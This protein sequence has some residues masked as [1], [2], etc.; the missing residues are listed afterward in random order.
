MGWLHGEH[1]AKI[2]K[3]YSAAVCRFFESSSFS[4]ITTIGQSCVARIIRVSVAQRGERCPPSVL[5]LLFIVYLIGRKMIPR[6]IS[7]HLAKNVRVPNILLTRF[8]IVIRDSGHFVNVVVAVA[9][10]STG[11][12]TLKAYVRCTITGRSP[13]IRFLAR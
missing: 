1:P 8:G 12:R 4:L 10:V 11:F 9:T 3:I 13:V 2:E 5:L 6:V 7:Y